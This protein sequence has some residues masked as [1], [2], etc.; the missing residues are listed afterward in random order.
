MTGARVKVLMARTE[1]K[2][3]IKMPKFRSLPQTSEA[4]RENV[5]RALHQYAVLRRALHEPQNG[6][7]SEYVWERNEE[8]KSLQLVAFPAS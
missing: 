8:T 1:R 4:F 3:S 2:A 5:K 6:D 7:P